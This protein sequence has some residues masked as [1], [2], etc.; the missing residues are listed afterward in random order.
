MLQ[1]GTVIGGTMI[2][3]PKSFYTACNIATQVVSS[4]ASSQYG[5]QTI[6]LSHL[7]PFVDVSRK[8]IIKEV[9]EDGVPE[10]KRDEV[11]KRRLRKEIRSGVQTIQ[12]QLITLSTTN[13][14][15]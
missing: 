13:G 9:I 12:Y 6:T 4:V 8:K 7:A 2:E 14:L 10:E 3:T 1:N 11:I 5:G 15:V